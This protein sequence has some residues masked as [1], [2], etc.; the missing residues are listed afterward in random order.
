VKHCRETMPHNADEAHSLASVFF[1]R[2]RTSWG[3]GFQTLIEWQTG[4]RTAEALK[5]RTDAQPHEPGW[6]TEDGK[7]LY[8]RRVKKQHAVMPFCVVHDGLRAIL[9]AHA[10]WKVTYY[11]ESPWYF[12]SPDDPTQPLAS[13]SLAQA[14]GRIDDSAIG[15]KVTPHGLRAGHVLIRRSQGAMDSVIAA[16]LGHTTGGSTV[17]RVYGGIPENWLNGGGP[18]LSWLPKTVAWAELAKNGWK[19][20]SQVVEGL[21]EAA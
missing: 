4:I 21:E 5:L 17:E 11:P 12:P 14:L 18:N 15:H 16:E 6:V 7:S 8:V 1:A 10:I 9:D 3:L 20:L 19:T 13:T 2:R